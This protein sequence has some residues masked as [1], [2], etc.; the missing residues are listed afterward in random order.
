VSDA[1]ERL[2]QYLAQR[3]E[4]GESEFVLD[5]LSVEEAMRVLTTGA[6]PPTAETRGTASSARGAG[7]PAAELP[8]SSRTEGMTDDWRAALDAVGAGPKAAGAKKGPPV[9]KPPSNPPSNPP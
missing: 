2:R 1:H 7:A 3:R 4:M 8:T 9:S 6:P 5:S